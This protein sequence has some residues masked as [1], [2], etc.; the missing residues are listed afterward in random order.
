MRRAENPAAE[1]AAVA[2]SVIAGRLSS[3]AGIF[4]RLVKDISL[5]TL[6]AF[7]IGIIDL[8]DPVEAGNGEHFLDVSL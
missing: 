4:M 2:H 1:A 8:E 5:N 3:T 6:Q 7:G